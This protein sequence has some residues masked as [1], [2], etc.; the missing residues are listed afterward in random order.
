MNQIYIAALFVMISYI[1]GQETL[2]CSHEALHLSIEEPTVFT[3]ISG[4]YSK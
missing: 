1:G 2:Y 4:I 3:Q